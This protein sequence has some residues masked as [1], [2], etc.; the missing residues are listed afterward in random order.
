MRSH[1]NAEAATLSGRFKEEIMPVDIPQKKGN[2]VPF[3]KDEHYRPGMTMDQLTKLKP[4]FKPD[5]TVTAGNS[6]GIN[7]AAAA[8]VL[9]AEEKQRTR[10]YPHCTPARLR[11]G[12]GGTGVDGLRA[13]ARHP[14]GAKRTG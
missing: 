5:G 12:R 9:V 11:T 14:S 13:R 1:N 2:P 3:D 10:R 4:S 6:S 7:D 8:L